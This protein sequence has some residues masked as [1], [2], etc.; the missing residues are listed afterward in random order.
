MC[1]YD[2]VGVGGPLQHRA[3]FAWPALRLLS[4]GALLRHHAYELSIFAALFPHQQL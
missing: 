3:V 1:V 2:W 4:R